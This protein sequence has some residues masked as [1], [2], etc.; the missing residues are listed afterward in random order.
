MFKM[1]PLIL[2][3]LAPVAAQGMGA[4][5]DVAKMVELGTNGGFYILAMYWIRTDNA[6]A[7]ARIDAL[8]RDALI[9]LERAYTKR[10]EE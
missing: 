1:V 3:T 2:A 6:K 4:D 7:N 8:C 5:P 10:P 9:R